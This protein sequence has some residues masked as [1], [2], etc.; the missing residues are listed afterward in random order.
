V[1]ERFFPWATIHIL[2]PMN[3]SI[4]STSR[5]AVYLIPPYK[6]A[7]DVAEIHW[8]LCKQFGLTAASRFQVHATIKG[9]FKKS[10]DPLPLLV[11]RLD[12]VFAAQRPFEVHFNGFR[13][14]DIGLGLDISHR[15]G[16][17]N[18][19]FLACRERVVDAVLPYVAPDCDFAK[20]DL[21]P[22][23]RAH[24]TFAF[25]DISTTMYDHILAWLQD[26]PLPIEPF[27]ADAFHFLEFFSEDWEG[28]WWETLTWRLHKVWTLN[29]SSRD[30]G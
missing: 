20:S 24:I 6:I 5:F 2:P 12:A 15:E 14:N 18:P 16:K 21:E 7:R 25:R 10:E 29:I 13:L 30:L 17:L 23:F 9:F 27:L 1:F 28:K 26:A 8:I 19:E 4:P 3:L 11:E 22:P